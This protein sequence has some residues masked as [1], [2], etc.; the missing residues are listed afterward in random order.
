MIAPPACSC[1]RWVSVISTAPNPTLSKA[2]RNSVSVSA[3]AM[4]PV[5][6]AMSARVGSSMSG[7]AITSETA[8]RPPGRSTRAASQITRGLSPERLITQFEMTTSTVSSASGMSS[9]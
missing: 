8:N 3:P 2:E 4:H 5:H 7:S 6:A 9:R 1:T